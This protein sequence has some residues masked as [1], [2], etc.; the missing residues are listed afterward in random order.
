[1]FKLFIYTIYGLNG[2]SM[3][4]KEIP[5]LYVKPQNSAFLI[6]GQLFLDK[7]KTQGYALLE[8]NF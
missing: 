3:V 6:K 8:N 5:P 7:N 4:N 2:L 1:M